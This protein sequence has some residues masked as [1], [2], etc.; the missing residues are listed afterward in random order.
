MYWSCAA[1]LKDSTL[2]QQQHCSLAT[3]TQ[4]QLP[5]PRAPGSGCSQLSDRPS[6]PKTCRSQ[7]CRRGSKSATNCLAVA[8]QKRAEAE[9]DKKKAYVEIPAAARGTL[10][11]LTCTPYEFDRF[12][13][14]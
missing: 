9:R 1:A 7:R 8:E 11:L 2:N 10:L 5:V 13:T 3:G 14:F 6:P 4:V 12:E